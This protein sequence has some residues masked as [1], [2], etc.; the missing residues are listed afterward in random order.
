VVPT[1]ESIVA[2]AKS[3][4][5][6]LD[7]SRVEEAYFLAQ[8]AHEG[9]TR[10]SGQ[11]YITHPLETAHILL[12]LKPD[13]DTIL[14]ALL[15]D[16]PAD[17]EVSLKT[18]EKKFGHAVATLVQS[19]EKLSLVKLKDGHADVETWRRMFL[20]MAKDLRVIFI[21]LSERLHNMRTL[22]ALPHVKQVRIAQETL[23]VYAP[24][25]SR[26]GLYSFKT[27]LEDLC[28]QVLEP[29][30]FE[31]L[32]EQVRGKIRIHERFM[33]EAETI[34]KAL[35]KQEGLTGEVHGRLKHLYSIYRKMQV[36]N[37]QSV[38]D[39]LDF[40]AVRIILP[41]QFKQDREF[42]AHCYS[43]IGELHQKCMPLPGRFK[44]YIAVPK[45][46]GY[47]S[48]HTTVQGLVKGFEQYPLEIQ[49]R[50]ASMHQESEY[51][52]AAHWFYKDSSKGSTQLPREELHALLH[53][54]RLLSNFHDVLNRF[55][56]Q[57]E[58]AAINLEPFLISHGFSLEE[59]NAIK[60]GLSVSSVSPQTRFF[61]HQIDWVYALERLYE[62]LKLDEHGVAGK[63]KDLELNLF[64]D[65]IFVL[66]PKGD[67][68][69]LPLGSTPVDF[70]YSVHSD[71]G[72]RCAQAKVNGRIVS[73][74]HTLQSG[75]VVEIITRAER[76]PSRY[77]LYFL[78][79]NSAKDHI[80]NWFKR[81]DRDHFIRTGRELL[82]K[83]LRRM[84][85]AGLTPDYRLLA[86]YGGNRLSLT[87]REN[88]LESLGNGSLALSML[89]KTLFPEREPFKEK[90][91]V[92]EGIAPSAASLQ[93]A[94]DS[95]L[96]TGQSDLP[97][98]IASCCNPVPPEAIVGYVGR[99][100]SIRIH[101]LSCR[102]LDHTDGA[103]LLKASWA[104]SAQP[105]KQRN[106]Y[107][108]ARD[109]LGLLRDVTAV[110]A[111]LNINIIDISIPTKVKNQLTCHLLA[112][113]DDQQADS[114]MQHL[115][116]IDGVREI[117]YE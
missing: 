1:L 116:K 14:A 53:Q 67:V 107:I 9:Q 65:R 39:I 54:R 68:K 111:D 38:D 79:L 27:E 16:V 46:N 75:D 56:E 106:F 24:I 103:R 109:R 81:N 28:L 74:D 83:E 64:K 86:D 76:Q 62:D 4:L 35:L 93:G 40:F 110:I 89:T 31:Y 3:Y 63:D 108:Q 87:D 77:W 29:D 99:G 12:S 50:T 59:A 96:I 36:K 71:V 6:S 104:S 47:R 41:D 26:L 95:I 21:R 82:N 37:A 61:Q 23:Y 60:E 20:A 55:P 22:W 18:I 115:K 25:A 113:L 105:L 112:E 90:S 73:L 43:F 32:S 48:I 91:K 34:L 92:G 5:P 2:Q 58:Q 72:H 11:P 17:T 44:D 42:F 69:D 66:T 88:L 94:T 19:N 33:E 80:K 13:E 30:I 45:L 8:K 7:Q 85:K 52:L 102:N 70:A 51:G 117:R 100:S 114:F 15:H 10:R 98:K 57:R 84:G 97:F 49:V 78:K 101:S